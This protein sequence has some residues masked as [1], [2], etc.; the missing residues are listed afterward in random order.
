MGR[1]AL[2]SSTQKR[3]PS[4]GEGGLRGAEAL[5]VTAERAG[6]HLPGQHQGR[7]TPPL[8]VTQPQR[9]ST[10]SVFSK[11]GLPVQ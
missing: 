10:C 9:K 7:P 8:V 2:F 4:W 3:G 5:P 6:T 1:V 11:S